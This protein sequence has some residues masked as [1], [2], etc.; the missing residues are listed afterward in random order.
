MLVDKEKLKYA[1]ELLDH[2]YIKD[3]HTQAALEYVLKVLEE[4]TND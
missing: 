1:V 2:L 4:L 3:I